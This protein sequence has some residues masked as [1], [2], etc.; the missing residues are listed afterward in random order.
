MQDPQNT[1]V[2]V[3]LTK[4]NEKPNLWIFGKISPADGSNH[5]QYVID[6]LPSTGEQLASL[7]TIYGWQENVTVVDV[8]E[9]PN[10]ENGK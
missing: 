9:M 4:L 10:S 2:Q 7:R 6:G 1:M 3:A 8:T 5:P